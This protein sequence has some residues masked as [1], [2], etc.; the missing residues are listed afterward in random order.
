MDIAGFLAQHPPFHG[1]DPE[2]LALIAESVQ[3]E[4]FPSGTTILE[5]SG[6]PADFLYVVRKGAVEI[7]DDGRIRDL[8]GEGEIF[9]E[10]SV[11]TGRPPVASVHAA[12]DTICYL[13]PR[14]VA[15]AMLQS[16]TGVRY[17][18][19]VARRGFEPGIARAEGADMLATVG[20]QVRRALVTVDPGATVAD[21]AEMMTRERVSSL[22]IPSGDGAWGIVTDRDLR[23]RVLALGRSPDVPVTEVMTTPI[24]TVPAVSRVAEVLLAMLERGIHHLPVTDAKGN[25]VGMVTDTDLLGLARQSPFAIRSKIERAGDTASAVSA[26]RELPTAAASLVDAS[27]D[28]VDIGHVISVTIDT[29]TRRLL[30]LGI[31]RLGEPPVAWAWL[32]LGS[33]ARREQALFTDQD[34]A[35]ALDAED[36]ALTEVDP[37]FADLAHEVTSGLADA[38]IHRCDGNAMAEHPALRRSVAG[39]TEAFRGWI[40]EPGGE[41][42]VLPSIA[43]DYRQIAG[44]L[45]AEPPLDE[46]LRTV[47]RAYPWFARH[48]GRRALDLGPPT[49]FLRDLVVEAK[50]DHAGRLDIKHGGITIVTNLARVDDVRAGSTQKGTLAR[51][52][53]AAAV[54]VISESSRE[55]LEETFRLLWGIRLDHQAEQHRTGVQPDDFVD[56]KTL[57]PVRRQALKEAFRI[58]ATEQRGLATDLGVML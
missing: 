35:L 44:P 47:P 27:V 49:G 4:F 10:L 9:G 52:R 34:H 56:P 50:G 22:L 30:E 41:G 25:V 48:L 33:E 8:L 37:Y 51:L 45:A 17:L 1:S 14:P 12:E 7:V 38:G 54:G 18:A 53:A 2:S 23:S 20:A 24:Q 40:E 58:I 19:S 57:G 21:A 46:L 29:L 28:P 6:D 15:E 36:E 32:T 5:S 11:A 3:V 13:I 43:F 39:W 55:A 31:E 16:A 42:G 26:A